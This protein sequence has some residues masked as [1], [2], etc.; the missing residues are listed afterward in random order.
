[1]LSIVLCLLLMLGLIYF[2]LDNYKTFK[3]T[4]D[5]AYAA[6]FAV[7]AVIFIAMTY[8]FVHFKP[9]LLH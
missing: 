5:S 8:G 9:W 3:V 6:F 4:R 1:M 7:G 2:M